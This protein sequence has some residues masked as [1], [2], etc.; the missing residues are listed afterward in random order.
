[1][2]EAVLLIENTIKFLAAN[3]HERGWDGEK[4]IMELNL[5]IKAG[6]I[7]FFIFVAR[8]TRPL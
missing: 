5:L 8:I 2:V 6:S 1:L 7:L 3:T 4:C